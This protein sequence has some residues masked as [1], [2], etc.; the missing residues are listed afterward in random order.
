[1]L[2]PGPEVVLLLAWAWRLGAAA[3]EALEG[4]T[5]G[6]DQAR[7]QE[8]AGKALDRG[9]RGR[10]AGALTG[11]IR[12][13]G[14]REVADEAAL[15]DEGFGLEPAG[16]HG[17]RGTLAMRSWPERGGVRDAS[18]S[19][20]R[21]DG[22]HTLGANRRGVGRRANGGRSGGGKSGPAGPRN[23]VSGTAIVGGRSVMGPRPRPRF[24]LV[25]S[26]R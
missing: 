1:H 9:P 10:V 11:A 21:V 16:H 26:P 5:V 23:E 15:P 24:P 25:T 18:T 7:E 13:H 19:M 12:G 2:A 14:E 8:L 3:E 4:V 6:V 22:V 17:P 20:R